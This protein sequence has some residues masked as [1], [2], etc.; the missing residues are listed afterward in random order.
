[1]L[2]GEIFICY[3]IFEIVY[4]VR[5]VIPDTPSVSGAR[6]HSVRQ[7]H[8]HKW[9]IFYSKLPAFV[10]CCFEPKLIGSSFNRHKM[11]ISETLYA[12]VWIDRCH[13]LGKTWH[14]AQLACHTI[15]RDQ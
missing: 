4:L 1:M 7:G 12:I 10:K 11:P 6:A 3:Y 15:V 8:P 5:F 13:P 2:C 9:L 14:S